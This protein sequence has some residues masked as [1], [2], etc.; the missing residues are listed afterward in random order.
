MGTEEHNGSLKGVEYFA[1]VCG[2]NDVDIPNPWCA[3][4]SSTLSD[5]DIHN[6]LPGAYAV[7]GTQTHAYHSSYGTKY[8]R[9]YKQL[10][11]GLAVYEAVTNRQNQIRTS[12]F[13]PYTATIQNVIMILA[14]VSPISLE[15]TPKI[16]S[17]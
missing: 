10:I 6:I 16:L 1:D 12:K 8:R 9:V 5:A 17:T 14:G 2:P 3:K 15:F 7:G 11:S 13:K 4:E